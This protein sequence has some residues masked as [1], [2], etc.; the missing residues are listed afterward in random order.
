LLDDRKL[1]EPLCESRDLF[2]CS[3]VWYQ[4]DDVPVSYGYSLVV[5][6]P[7]WHIYG[8]ETGVTD[9]LSS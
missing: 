7:D 3:G 4:C 8:P 6:S 5:M 1:S 9:S 2:T